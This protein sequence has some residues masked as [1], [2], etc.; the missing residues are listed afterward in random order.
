MTQ[1]FAVSLASMLLLAGC[2]RSPGEPGGPSARPDRAPGGQ[3]PTMDV[4]ARLLAATSDAAASTPY[5][6]SI[7]APGGTA[8][9]RFERGGQPGAALVGK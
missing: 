7:P 1:I 8:F 4:A 6:L 2:N 3:P 9:V 5:R